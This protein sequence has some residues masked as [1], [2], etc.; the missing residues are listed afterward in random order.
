MTSDVDSSKRAKPD[1]RSEEKSWKDS[2]PVH[3]AACEGRAAD[4]REMLTED[5]SQ[6]RLLDDDGWEPI[7]YAAWYDQVAAVQV[8]LQFDPEVV[9]HTTVETL[10]TPLHYAAGTGHTAVCRILIE[11]GAK[12]D[13]LDKEKNTPLVLARTLKE[14]DWEGVVNLLGTSGRFTIGKKK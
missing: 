4:L 2:F 5:K 6:A 11:R 3:A 7:H 14:N 9:N 13:P 1:A 10:S 8:L 12:V